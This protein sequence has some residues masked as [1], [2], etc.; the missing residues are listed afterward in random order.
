[1]KIFTIGFTKTTAE[2][3]FSRIKTSGAKK[4]IDT[5]LKNVSQLAGFAKGKDLEF[6][7]KEICGADYEHNLELA[8]TKE[9]LD[10]YKKKEITWQKYESDFIELIRDRAIEN[11]DPEELNNSCLLCS[12]D[13]PHFCHRRLVAEYLKKAWKSI[14]IIHL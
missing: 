4:I 8:P 11:I 12:E 9:I 13:T 5:R 3:F 10:A 2:N 14:E 6:F 1:M 7:S